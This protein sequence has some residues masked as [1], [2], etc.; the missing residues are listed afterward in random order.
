MSSKM[1][2]FYHV[3]I[4]ATKDAPVLYYSKGGPAASRISI[5]EGYGKCRM[6]GP[7]P[8]LLH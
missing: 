5:T 7:S 2:P 3:L 1:M 6:L 8:D 4:T